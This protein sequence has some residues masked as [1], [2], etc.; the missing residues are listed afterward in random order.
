MLKK[1]KNST[2]YVG[3]LLAVLLVGGLVA[4]AFGSIFTLISNR[5]D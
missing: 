2:R 4:S 5:E 3:I 1:F